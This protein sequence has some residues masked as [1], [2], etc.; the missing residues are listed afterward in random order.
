MNEGCSSFLIRKKEFNL[1]KPLKILKT[2]LFRYCLVLKIEA[3]HT[4]NN[5]YCHPVPGF[6]TNWQQLTTRKLSEIFQSNFKDSFYSEIATDF[7][8]S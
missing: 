5:Q 7:V 3:F 4:K 2:T 1:N 6:T 8:V